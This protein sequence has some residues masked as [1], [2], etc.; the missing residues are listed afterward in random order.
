MKYICLRLEGCPCYVGRVI[1]NIDV[2]CPTPVW[3]VERLRRSGI[4]SIDAIVD[5]TNYVMLEL[6]QPMHAFD[7]DQLTGPS[8]SGWRMTVSNSYFLMERRLP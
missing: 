8:M 5:I 1:D 2:S 7:R 6:G 3:M 4:R